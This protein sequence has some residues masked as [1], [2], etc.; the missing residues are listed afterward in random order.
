VLEHELGRVRDGVAGG[1]GLV[2]AAAD[3]LPGGDLSHQ[4]GQRYR[5]R[6][7]ADRFTPGPTPRGQQTSGQQV[8]LSRHRTRLRWVPVGR[9]GGPVEPVRRR[10]PPFPPPTRSATGEGDEQVRGGGGNPVAVLTAGTERA[11][12]AATAS[13]TSEA[14]GVRPVPQA[15]GVLAQRCSSRGRDRSGASLLP[16]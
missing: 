9:T 2:V 14:R 15:D 8:Q 10:S 12:A 1:G 5:Q 7:P 4:C 16:E 3:G 6:H 11:R 13:S